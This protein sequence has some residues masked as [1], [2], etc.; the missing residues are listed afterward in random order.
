MS[1]RS[2]STTDAAGT[3]AAGRKGTAY[4]PA[5]LFVVFAGLSMLG[6]GQGIDRDAGDLLLRLRIAMSPLPLSPRIIPV[7]LN[8]RSERNLGGRV[9]DR[10]AFAALL[11]ILGEGRL[12]GALD[13][14]FQ[15]KRDAGFDSSMADSAGRMEKLVLAVV[16][17]P[18]ELSSFS[19]SALEE[20]DA[21]ILRAHLW[22]PRVVV[23]GDVPE[24]G[25]F[26]MPNR[27]LARKSRFFGHIAVSPD[28][29]GIYRRLP[30][31]YR[32]ED[33]YIPTLSLALAV[34]DMGIDPSLVELR[35]GTE[36][37]IPR[38]DG[39]AISI[40]IDRSATAWVPLPGPWKAGWKRIPLD[41]V[42]DAAGNAMA[43]DS[44]IEAWEGSLVIAADITTTHKDF[45]STP[46]EA[47]YPLSGIHTSLLNGILTGT[48]FR[49]SPAVVDS[50][51][52]L[53]LLSG[54]LFLTL[55]R[56]RSFLQPGFA[57][58]ALA[59]LAWTCAAWFL[60]L[61]MPWLA[62]P[63]LGLAAAWIGASAAGI[64]RSREERLLLENALSRYFPRALAARVLS[65]HNAELRPESRELTILFADIANFTGWSSDKSPELV[66]EFL[67]NYLD[68]MSAVLFEHGA[69]VDKFMGDGIMAFF[70][71]P[72]E[73]PDHADRALRAALDMQSK[74][75]Q[76]RAEWKDKA[77]ID[78]RIRIGVNSG[79]VIVGN[80]GSKSRIEYTVIGAAVNLAQR[81][82]SNAPVEGILIAAETRKRAAG[83]FVFGEDRHVK[84]KGYDAPVEAYV[85]LEEKG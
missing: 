10:Q 79:R 66:H 7:D 19:G 3:D 53:V 18:T 14:L 62:A 21:A 56:R 24:A 49:S 81:M 58:L 2:A 51:V 43:T 23:A 73:Q 45:G 60:G 63:A 59:L 41:K 11:S 1:R 17:V 64:L 28:T 72:L 85:L 36:L 50:L 8:D 35:A 47:V 22:H 52:C 78:L 30:L 76:L 12:S 31:L 68:S 42:V 5:V 71:D 4:L 16:P 26:L 82:E 54:I 57:I 40:P 27:E 15:G 34:A 39:S 29:D 55:P 33:G 77:G 65:G 48:F 74:A 44:I 80:L 25:T 61:V 37:R 84:A 69:T 46:L 13:F 9:D 70:G 38:P 32:W 20:E 83:N 67:G 75:A 6:L